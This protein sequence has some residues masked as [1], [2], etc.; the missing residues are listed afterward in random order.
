MNKFK[1]EK[2][3]KKSSEPGNRPVVFSYIVSVLDGSFLSKEGT[4]K[5]L[6]FAMLLFGFGII[7]IYMSHNFEK[8]VREYNKLS[9]SIKDL[10]SEYVSL[11]SEL[12]YKSNQS[13]LAKSL[14]RFDIKESKEPP[15]KIFKKQD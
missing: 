9:R 6:P 14:A 11:K 3:S 13:Q 8:K 2:Q 7:Y 5:N 12:T 1:E 4:L 10:Q 15:K